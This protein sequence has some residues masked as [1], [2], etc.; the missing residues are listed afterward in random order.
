MTTSDFKFKLNQLVARIDTGEAG[1]VRERGEDTD[2][3]RR[4][5]V[6]YLATDGTQAEDWWSE[7]DITS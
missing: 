5:R 4:Y 6:R 1:H 7:D 2:G 3:A